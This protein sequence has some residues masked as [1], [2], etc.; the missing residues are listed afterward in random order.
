MAKKDFSCE[1]LRSKIIETVSNNGGHLASSLGAVEI[2]KALSEVFDSETDRILW[3]VGHQAYAWKILTGRDEEFSTIR[4]HGGISPFCNPK[5]S[6]S[7]AAISGHA[8]VAL[9]NALGMAVARDINS[10][11]ESVV[12]VIGDSS[13][14]N[15]TSFEALNNL[16]SLNTKVIV[17]L[18]DNK[19]GISKTTGAV[20]RFLGSLIS[21]IRY[22]KIK[23]AAEN[24]GHAFKLTFLRNIYHF[25]ESS[26]KSL[27][28]ANQMFEQFG[29]RY[30]GPIDGHNTKRLVSAFTVAKNDK[31]SV[32]VHVVT[33]KGKGFKPAELHPAL[34]HGTGPFEL[35]AV[36]K[37]AEMVQSSK[38]SWSD[39]FGEILCELAQGDERIVALTAGM[40]DGTG[41]TEFAK[42][43]PKRFFDVGIAEGHM[44]SF[45]AGLA[46][47]GLRPVV[48]VYSTFLQR[49]IDQIMHDVAITNLNVI[50]CVDRSGVV[51]S[52]G[53]TH[54]GLY[55]IAMLKALPNVVISQPHTKEDLKDIL[56]ES[57]K[58]G[59]VRV[60]RYPKGK[61]PNAKERIGENQTHNPSF[62]LWALGDCYEKA[63][64]VASKAGGIA[65]YSKYIKPF[66]AELLLEQ[67]KKGLKIISVEN[68][69]AIGGFGESI[70]AELRFGWPDKFIEHG[71]VEELEHHYKLDEESMIE[72]IKEIL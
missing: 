63:C 59:G 55:D 46:A 60:V 54:Q 53:V 49:S 29:L 40:K 66:D 19:M 5:E 42:R 28:L 4:R 34:W 22:N 17:V 33:K 52:D 50:F 10:G 8:G 36:S 18:N 38:N 21:G 14:V 72:K 67:R 37:S 7:D 15:G 65:V 39:A 1:E 20:S 69:S 68:G 25:L 71:S 48:A 70:G 57:V 27:F 12:A 32:I 24:A 11:S 6:V 3:D 35:D 9:S 47:R 45:A 26:I 58:S 61:V 30:I 16:I 51:G 56:L 31:R 62:A 23:T 64:R 41:L 43:F 44:V 13:I 2:A